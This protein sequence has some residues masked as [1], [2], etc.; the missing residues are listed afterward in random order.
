MAR[1]RN[2]APRRGVV[3]LVIL[4]LLVL[5]ALLGV[6]FVI[7]SGQYKRSAGSYMRAETYGDD[8]ARQIDTAMYVALRDSLD[9]ANP[10]RT[11]SLL[12]DIY[13]HDSYYGTVTSASNAAL[14]GGQLVDI[15]CTLLNASNG[16]L[17][18]DANVAGYF[19][20]CVLTFYRLAGAT[21]GSNPLAGNSTRIVGSS[22]DT[23]GMVPT[24]IIRAV[25]PTADNASD[26]LLKVGDKFLIN[27]R[28]FSGAGAGFNIATG[29]LDQTGGA[30]LLA[31]SPNQRSVTNANLVASSGYAVGRLNES[32][33]APDLQNLFLSATIPD[34]SHPSGIKHININGKDY[35]CI[36]PS[37]HRPALIQRDNGMTATN[38]FRPLA[39]QHP[40][41]PLL[42]DQTLASG[43]PEDPAVY[44]PWDVDND[45][46]GIADSIWID[47]NL[48]VQTSPDGRRYKPLFAI[49]IEDLDNRIN[50]N[51]Q[52]N[53]LHYA[54]KELTNNLY[55]AD[56]SQSSN[57]NVKGT[58]LGPPEVVLKLGLGL[59]DTQY[60]QVLEGDGTFP[61][62]Y[63]P[64]QVAGA[65]ASGTPTAL[66]NALDPIGA[67]RFYEWPSTFMANSSFQSAADLT[68]QLAR[69]VGS[70]GQLVMDA[71]TTAGDL[72]ERAVYRT[73][74]LNDSRFVPSELE[75]IL[76]YYDL[77]AAQLPGRLERLAGVLS[78]GSTQAALNRRLVTTASYDVPAA[79]ATP[80]RSVNATGNKEVFRDPLALL[81][82]RLG[83]SM[84]SET[85]ILSLVDRDFYFGLKMNLNRPLGDG[86]DNNGNNVIDEQDTTEATTAF[87]NG[88]NAVNGEDV[89][90]NG[91]SD[92]TDQ[93]YARHLFAK[94]LYILA[95]LCVDSGATPNM[96]VQK[97]LAQ[98]AVNVVDFRDADSIMTPFEYDPNPFDGW[99]ST[100]DGIVGD[101]VTINPTTGAAYPVESI[102]DGVVV[103]AA[104]P[105]RGLVWGLER[106]ELLLT[107]TMVGHDRRSSDEDDEDPREPATDMPAKTT[108]GGATMN[109][110]TDF[111]Q[112]YLPQG[113]A[114]IELYAPWRSQVER[115]PAELYSNPT[116]GGV[117]LNKKDVATNTSPVWRM[118]VVKGDAHGIDP[119]TQTAA[120]RTTLKNNTERSVYFTDPTALTDDE[121]GTPYFADHAIDPVLPGAYAVVGTGPASADTDG[122]YITYLGLR[123]DYTAGITAPT[124]A[125]L[126]T[127]RRFVLNPTAAAGAAKFQVLS[128]GHTAQPE[129]NYATQV[130]PVV[131]VVVNKAVTAMGA[132]P[133]RFTFSEPV[134]GY[135]LGSHQKSAELPGGLVPLQNSTTTMPTPIDVPL[136]LKRTDIDDGEELYKDGVLKQWRFVHLQRLANP[137][138]PWNKYSNPYLTIDTIGSDIYCFNGINAQDDKKAGGGTNPNACE[139]LQRG[140]PSPSYP[141]TPERQLWRRT[142]QQTLEA[143]TGKIAATPEADDKHFNGYK[144][145]H[146]LGYLNTEYGRPHP[147]VAS[148]MPD[149]VNG[150]AVVDAN[151]PTFPWLT[152][153]NRPFN[154]VYELMDVPMTKSSQLT[155]DFRVPSTLSSPYNQDQSNHVF[156]HLPN[157]YYDQAAPA[158]IN[159]LYRIF[160]YL[161]IPSKFVEADTMF[162][163][164]T[165]ATTDTNAQN[166]FHPP[167]NWLSNF[168]DPGLININTIY[169]ANVWHAV[170]GGS[171]AGNEMYGLGPTFDKLVASR[172]GYGT[173]GDIFE[174]DGS[175]PTEFGNP[176][177]AAGTGN[178]GGTIST[179]NQTNPIDATFLRADKDPAS[180][181]A[182]YPLL[183]NALGSTA[184]TTNATFNNS[185]RHSYFRHQTLHRL[186]N[187][188]TTR[189]N[190]Y[191]CWIT[192]GYFEIPDGST[193]SLGQ[194]LHAD[195]GE[196]KRH[197]AFYLID[198]TIPV[199]FQPG[200]NHNVD[201]AIL[202]RRY[203]E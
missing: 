164:A 76:R 200:E 168:R 199:G 175:T 165:F 188:L 136:D 176:F 17:P 170:L 112:K 186:S 26:V 179:M 115:R 123:N 180:S 118:L 47:L 91:S 61:G 100:C 126:K 203:I 128:N 35:P 34:T 14:G 72:R 59:S 122:N 158:Q 119:D 133:E 55:F 107:E 29:N 89:N 65:G 11:H 6:T 197:R 53:R 135:T 155:R 64:D 151:N 49:K 52:G 117:V 178:M 142:T 2:R 30:G 116:T 79:V 80:T 124:D 171:P 99:E 174:R 16:P 82:Q 156:G 50:V 57:W 24:Y 152:W 154:S 20:G 40:N 141:A 166:Q 15:Q 185:A 41:F 195:T 140:D 146:T 12:N 18:N 46:D 19:N 87:G 144:L 77:D 184:T 92:A 36:I 111:D 127:T 23:S 104:G 163:A 21:P 37:F 120:E 177:R 129:P 181:P 108:E 138:Q 113:F 132:A 83:G 194:E 75:R 192:V 74:Q 27:G 71:P 67:T 161:R 84:L 4:S 81:R 85:Q 187:T 189:S 73:R 3:L 31:L 150:D 60:Q 13:G 159:G 102:N 134:G 121:D 95:S 149:V 66:T 105:P 43:N 172:R 173:S 196:V 110:D 198:R 183:A 153:N 125:E 160:D 202:V 190:V 48:P 169:H 32:W 139:T 162:T 78:G 33:D 7:V 103:P 54:A 145:H 44:G 157:F 193:G 45:G 97:S 167:F 94:H 58:G 109:P 56:G 182:N 191:A 68:G 201:R 70:Q 86:A 130:Q 10:L 5:F 9:A 148:T 25:R 101:G 1:Q 63:G 147:L 42:G 96:A 137:L 106:P 143:A 28:A 38:S 88:F 69:G 93:L 131:P 114:F 22:V 62:R 8:W 90:G 98:W 39:A 51:F